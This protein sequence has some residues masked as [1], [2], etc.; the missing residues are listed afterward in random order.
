MT[1]PI[2]DRAEEPYQQYPGDANLQSGNVRGCFDSV[3]EDLEGRTLRHEFYC[4]AMLNNAV[5]L[6]NSLYFG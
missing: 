1:I 5:I 6:H 2:F 4:V 3:Y